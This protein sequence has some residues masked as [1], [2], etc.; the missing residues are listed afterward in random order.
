MTIVSIE[1]TPNCDVSI[2][3]MG[4]VG[5]EGGREEGGGGGEEEDKLDLL[6]R[7]PDEA[8]SNF[9][10]LRFNKLVQR[11]KLWKINSPIKQFVLYFCDLVLNSLGP[12]LFTP[13]E[14]YVIFLPQESRGKFLNRS[15]FY[16]FY[17]FSK[18]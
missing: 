2:P 13:W 7:V 11:T 8:F 4:R 5:R 10:F 15:F 9:F 3:S 1:T 12:V 16:G 17:R 18:I 14:F 6:Q